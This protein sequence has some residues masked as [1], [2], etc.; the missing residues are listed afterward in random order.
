MAALGVSA[1]VTYLGYA[2]RDVKCFSDYVSNSC[3][4]RGC[5]ALDATWRRT[6]APGRCRH[7]VPRHVEARGPGE[8]MRR[9]GG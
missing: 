7:V 9:G 2:K 1:C 4:I 6:S 8:R 5:D 3:V